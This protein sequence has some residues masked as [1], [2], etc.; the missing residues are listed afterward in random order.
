MRPLTNRRRAVLLGVAA[1]L[2]LTACGPKHT[3]QLGVRDVSTDILLK[4]KKANTPVDTPQHPFVPGFPFV[5]TT[6]TPPSGDHV[7]LPPPPTV[8]PPPPPKVCPVAGPYAQP[9]F[10]APPRPAAGPVAKAYNVRVDGSYTITGPSASSGRYGPA[11][12]RTVSAS[13]PLPNNAGWTYSIA[14]EQGLTTAYETIP[15]Q[16][17]A[18][19]YPVNSANQPLPTEPGIYVT[20]FSYQRADGTKLTLNPSPPLMVAKLPLTAGDR[21]TSHSVDSQTGMAIVLNGQTG[22]GAKYDPYKSRVDACG[23]ILDGYWVEY[24]VDTTPV[25][26]AAG[27]PEPPSEITGSDIN[28]QFVGSRVAFG[29]QFGGIP[30]EELYTLKGTDRSYTVDI[31]RHSVYS[32]QPVLVGSGL[33]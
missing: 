13:T 7:T 6:V 22:I 14:D 11:G 10:G 16:L 9:T 27:N 5:P 28:I 1:A 21:W 15:Q 31:T 32:A 26:D 29:T 24:T 8:L 25:N 2:S 33:G 17:A 30:I 3:V 4:S 23:T 20:S 12:T 18:T 19:D